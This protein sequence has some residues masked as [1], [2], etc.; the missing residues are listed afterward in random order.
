MVGGR[1]IRRSLSAGP[2]LLGEADQGRSQRPP[3]RRELGTG[4]GDR[5]ERTRLV[6]AGLDVP[7]GVVLGPDPEDPVVDLGVPLHAP[8]GRGEARRLQ[9]AR[10]SLR[11]HAPHRAAGP[12][13][14]RRSSAPRGWGAAAGRGHPGA[15][16]RRPRRSSRPRSGR[17]AGHAGCGRRARR[18]PARR[19]GDPGRCRAP[20]ARP[21][22]PRAPGPGWAPA[23]GDGRR[24]PPSSRRG[25]RAR[26]ASRGRRVRGGRRRRRDVVRRAR[27]RP[28]SAS[29]RAWPAGRRSRARPP[30]PG[31]RTPQGTSSASTPRKITL[32]PSRANGRLKSTTGPV[33]RPSSTRA[34]PT[35]M[36]S[37]LAR[38][39]A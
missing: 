17:P 12:A 38:A 2:D 33:S 31:P 37:R 27:R 3:G 20:G 4:V 11:Q 32:S 8:H 5:R 18:A 10:G 15:G 30:A 29:H 24:W 35:A 25:P 14:R 1:L 19:A 23:R 28:R 21:R 9:L 39:S 22:P 13:P 16:R 26:R 34:A 7:V 36:T 6:D